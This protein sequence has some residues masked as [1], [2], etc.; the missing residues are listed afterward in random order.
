LGSPATAVLT[1]V[2]N[3]API[4]SQPIPTLDDWAIVA[5]AAM[6]LAAQ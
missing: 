5:L 3:D 2:D 6:L 1:I 4:A